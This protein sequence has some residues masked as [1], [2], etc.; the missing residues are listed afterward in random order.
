MEYFYLVLLVL[1]AFG[2][3]AA[4]VYGLLIWLPRLSMVDTPNERTNHKAPTP[5]GGG[6][7]MSIS[8]LGFLTVSGLSGMVIAGA[9]V[10]LIVSFLDDVYS[11]S[12]KWRLLIQAVAVAMGL[13][14]LP[15]MAITAGFIP[16]WAERVLMGISWLWFVNLFN[17]MDGVDEISSLQALSICI[18]LLAVSV[19]VVNPLTSLWLDA[20]IV[21]AA[22]LGFWW[23]NR[24]PARIFMGDSG[25]VPL[26]YVLGFLLLYLAVKGQWVAA[27]I[28]PAYYMVDATI[29][30]L[31]RL[32]RGENIAQAHSSHA[33]QRAVRSW[34]GNH[35]A[36]TGRLLVL[37]LL[38]IALA[39]V[40]AMPEFTQYGLVCL[41]SAYGLALCWYLWFAS[42]PARAVVAPALPEPAPVA[43]A[44]I[45]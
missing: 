14:G 35:R 11:L 27:L 22:V 21:I 32:L 37:Q 18:G 43:I 16:L 2:L 25:S 30:L 9:V 29:T 10:L 19:L 17:F 20:P 3:S 34:G 39:T 8:M 28:L 24:H 23:F 6:L 36:L 42:R 13:S 33:Y 12:A 44:Q 38:L 4:G 41:M 1:S 15:D 7:A 31:R 45:G 40:S 26:G 5:R